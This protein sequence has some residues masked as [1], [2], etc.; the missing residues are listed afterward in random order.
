MSR[1]DFTSPFRDGLK[2]STFGGFSSL[3]KRRNCH[4]TPDF[5][6]F[7]GSFLC[8]QGRT[9]RGQSP[10]ILPEKNKT[11]RCKLPKYD[12]VHHVA[13]RM[14]YDDNGTTHL[15]EGAPNKARFLLGF[16]FSDLRFS[17]CTSNHVTMRKVYDDKGDN[18]CNRTN[19]I[20]L[21]S[22]E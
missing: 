7:H 4:G 5:C 10:C 19:C 18:L 9:T 16:A 8:E 21:S 12:K 6:V 15:V 2:N 17:P 13:I 1:E 14:I 3:I 20:K 11:Q 22:T